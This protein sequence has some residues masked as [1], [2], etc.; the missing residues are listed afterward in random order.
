M[1]PMPITLTALHEAFA[2]VLEQG[3]APGEVQQIAWLQ[4]DV[5]RSLNLPAVWIELAE[6]QNMADDGSGRLVFDCMFEVRCIADTAA[7]RQ[8]LLQVRSLAMR[9]AGALHRAVVLLPNTGRVRV[10][11]V[12]EAAFRPD[13]EAYVCWSVDVMVQVPDL[14]LPEDGTLPMEPGSRNLAKRPREV[15]LGHSPAIGAGNEQHYEQVNHV[16]AP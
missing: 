3:F 9:A 4:P 12:G 1:N 7:G 10:E 6:I 2:R 11:R 5:E 8:A 15:L 16:V 13:M 14:L